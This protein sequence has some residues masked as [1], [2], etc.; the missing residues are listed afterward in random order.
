MR[1]PSHLA[2]AAL[3]AAWPVLSCAQVERVERIEVTGSNIKRVD[4]ET[5]AALTVVTRD[6][7][8]RSGRATVAEYLQ[9][10][11]VDGQGSLRTS[12]GQGFAVGATAVSLRGLGAAA[13]LVL[14]NGRRM[15]PYPLA[16]DAQ[17]QFTDLS[18]V[19]LLAVERIEILRSGA[20]SIYGSDAMAGVVNILLRREFSGVE[21]SAT[22][23]TSR[24]RDATRS[25]GALLVGAGDLA[26]DGFNAY[27]SLEGRRSAEVH[28]RDRERDWIGKGDLR[29]WGY[30]PV[31]AAFVNGGA[32]PGRL[33]SP[34]PAGTLVVRGPSGTRVIGL[35]GCERFSTMPP[36]E[37]VGGC[38]IDLG[39]TFT[40]LPAVETT[41]LH[42][43]ATWRAGESLEAYGEV[44]LSRNRSG[45]DGT[46]N[47]VTPVL[48]T[49]TG[50]RDFRQL[51][52]MPAA[53]PD[54]PAGA[55]GVLR[56]SAPELGVRRRETQADAAR[57][58]VGLKGTRGAWEFDAAYAHSRVDLDFT[59]PSGVARIGALIEALA[60]PVTPYRIGVNAGLNA[61]GVVAA[62]GPVLSATSRSRQDVVDAKASTEL[63]MLGGGPLAL[64]LGAEARRE[65]FTS[66]PLAAPE[67]G[68]VNVGYQSFAG[69][70]RAWSAFGEVLAP[71]TPWLEATV[72][73]RHDHAQG[74]AAT[75]PK[76][77]LRLTPLRSLMLRA[78]YAEGFR[79]PS[80]P[81]SSGRSQLAA[82]TEPIA[83]PVRCPGG[84]PAPGANRI[85]CSISVA[86]LIRGNP[87]LRPERSRGWNA[88]F[89]W[90]PAV[91]TSLA[92]DAWV[93][94][95][96][97]EVGILPSPQAARRDDVLRGD[98]DLPGIP[99]S[100]TLLAA[101]AP[102]VN[103]GYT[104]VVGFD[105]DAAHRMRL[106]LGTVKLAAQW[107]RVNSS[108]RSE[109][110]GTVA[111]FAGT[112]GNC[113]VTDCAGTPRDR[114]R[115]VASLERGAVDATLLWTWRGP[116]DNVAARGE[117]CATTFAD[118][119]PAPDG[120]R[121]GGFNT[122]DATLR[123][124]PARDVELWGSVL[125]VADRV[126]PLDPLTYGSISY[127]P[128]DG[129]GAM[130]RYFAVGARVRFR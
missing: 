26:R 34:S 22:A 125:N 111:Q 91:G 59:L 115:L 19:P 118:D 44:D 80:V 42:G 15:A 52:V 105:V 89:I 58:L 112:H 12:F 121:L 17:R 64:A 82:A 69:D 119:R 60:D 32:I 25:G 8:L 93:I 103:T 114:V 79:A 38:G 117:P 2:G 87:A 43:R 128:L 27:A 31:G 9:S 47:S 46:Y 70:T 108:K 88:G 77:G 6:E 63:A 54:N 107:T 7:L 28:Y 66:P 124:R 110:D 76:A 92:Y 102:Y 98:D 33:P 67:L 10:L 21:A 50:L 113:G 130:G 56:Y 72:A 100:G 45:S 94:R 48:S 57:V 40:M 51:L 83:D 99:R 55:A 96:R 97:S 36:V 24:Y 23:G 16:D 41:L 13:T 14:V 127:N 81:E 3:A 35:P 4:V 90:E 86:L 85:D 61:P 120:C 49:P 62:I 106:P 101:V 71:L 84:A 11:T 20:S 74:F 29:E 104:Q 116:M 53:H 126:A 78:T 122:F 73:A 65:S 95:R 129:S 18:G 123:W 68:D 30:T 109:V 75:T 1:L 37:G 5:A 39:Q